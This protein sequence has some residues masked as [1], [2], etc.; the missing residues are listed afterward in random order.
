MKNDGKR[1]FTVI[2]ALMLSLI[3]FSLISLA[4]TASL[5][6][7]A[8]NRVLAQD[9]QKRAAATSVPET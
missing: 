3:L 6:L 7:R 5:R 4:A 9:L 8:S 1:G 2:A